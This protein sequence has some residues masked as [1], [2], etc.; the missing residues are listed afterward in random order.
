M[1]M[2]DF[3]RPARAALFLCVLLGPL[4]ALG[5]GSAGAKPLPPLSVFWQVDST[6]GADGVYGVALNVL[7]RADFTDLA[8]DMALPAGFEVLE[9]NPA[10]AGPLG[11]DETRTVQVRVRTRA[12]GTVTA[13]VSGK[14]ASNVQFQR[15]V[16]VDVPEPNQQP[17]EA[18]KTG[19]TD[20]AAS[21][22]ATPGIHE[23]PSR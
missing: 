11:R 19:P 2:P 14:T 3:R 5:A 6:A 9:G 7:A 10:W 4:A 12:P 18:V 16:S 22:D 15:T 21:G 17:S 8:V 20:P 13:R 23:L 1:Q